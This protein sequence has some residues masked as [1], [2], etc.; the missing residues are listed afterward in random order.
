MAY[1]HRRTFQT[2]FFMAT[3]LMMVN[4]EILL[5]LHQ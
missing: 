5:I 2:F 4:A 1:E 3:V